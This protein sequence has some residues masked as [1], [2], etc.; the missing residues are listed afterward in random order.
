MTH[1]SL[2]LRC[3]AAATL[4]ATA[5]HAQAG[6]SL[7]GRVT[8]SRGKGIE[9]VEVLVPGTM[10]HSRTGETGAFTLGAVPSGK[11]SL[12]ARRMGFEA[13][14]MALVLDAGEDRD[15]IIE[16]LPLAVTLREFK[17]E[18]SKLKSR[19]SDFE[20]R[21]LR[22]QGAFLTREDFMKRDPQRVSDIF[23]TVRGVR[24]I[25]RTSG[26]I[27]ESARAAFRAS[28]PMNVFVDGLPLKMDANSS[29]DTYVSLQHVAAV[30]V[31]SGISSVPPRYA[32]DVM[33]KCGVIVLWMRDG[34]DGT[35]Q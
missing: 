14:Q 25:P 5:L 12:I 10:H 3:A 27:V 33:A 9:G 20:M 35:E 18:S 32:N 21:K 8:D 30:E 2:L 26:V 22:E 34:P 7:A 29:I 23:R 16:L 24:L 13:V 4:G 11:V 19:F 15:V 28:C 17:V 31:Y 1:F 6:A